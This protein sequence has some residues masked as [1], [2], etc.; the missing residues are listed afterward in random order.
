VT[1]AAA[2]DHAWSRTKHRLAGG[3]PH[4]RPTIPAP[5]L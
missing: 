3:P 4:I 2:L 1:R 5:T